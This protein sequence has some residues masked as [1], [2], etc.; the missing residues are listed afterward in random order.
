VTRAWVDDIDRDE[1]KRI[2]PILNR[3]LELD[4]SDVNGYLDDLNADA[5]IRE[6]VNRFMEVDGHSG[7]LPEP[8]VAR[9][10]ATPPRDDAVALP[11]R[12]GSYRVL[13]ELG[14]GGMGIV[15]LGYDEVFGRVVA[16]KTLPP[17]FAANASRVA[18]F[19]GEARI[20]AALCHP[21]IATI[22]GVERSRNGR[23]VLV[24]E[25]VE[26]QTLA[27]RVVAGDWSVPEVL[28]AARQ[29][30]G[31]LAAAHARGV[32]H[33]DLKPSNVMVTQRGLAKVLDFGI[34]G[35]VAE[36]PGTSPSALR[37]TAQ[38]ETRWRMG[39]LGYMSP[40]QL[41]GGQESIACDAFSFG[42]VLYECLTGSPA[43]L[44]VNRAAT[45]DA[46]LR[47]TV[48]HSKLPSDVPD[49]VCIMLRSLLAREPADRPSDL[50]EVADVLAEGL[51]TRGPRSLRKRTLDDRFPVPPGPLV[52]RD[53]DLETCRDAL[54]RSRLVTLTGAG[55]CGKTR[56]A[57]ELAGHLAA[58]E[59]EVVWF[60]DLSSVAEEAGF[61]AALATALN[62]PG[63]ESSGMADAVRRQ[64][65]DR[66]GLLILD[67]CE[68]QL[69]RSAAFCNAVLSA[70]PRLTILATSREWLGVPGELTL[71]ID[72]L[73]VPE[74][75]FQTRMESIA[76]NDS[77][78]LFM[79]HAAA[80]HPDFRL[81]ESNA[82]DIA[83]V[84]RTLDGIPL[85]LEL[86]AALLEQFEL[87]DIVAEL[88]SRLAVETSIAAH[89][90]RHSTLAAAIELSYLRLDAIERHAFESMSV[91]S[92]GFTLE[93][94]TA[95]CG[96]D[97]DHFGMLD[98]LMHLVDR[99]LL[100][101]ERMHRPDLRYRYLEPVRVFAE[102][103]L[104]A[105][106]DDAEPRRRHG[107]HFCATAETLEPSLSHGNQIDAL[108]RFEADHQNLLAALRAC[109]TVPGL[110][111]TQALRL[112]K[113]TWR[114]WY[115]RGQFALGRDAIKAALALP[116]AEDVP[117]LRAHVM[118]GA[119]VL[120]LYLR[121]DA[122]AL[123]W[124]REALALH[125]RGGDRFGEASTL[126][127]LGAASLQ[128]GRYER[129]RVFFE[130]AQRLFEA[131]DEPRWLALMLNNLGAVA[132][133][134]GDL[135]T[136]S[137]RF[138]QAI[139]LARTINNLDDLALMLVNSALAHVRLGWLPIA[140]E[141]IDEALAVVRVAGVKRVATAALEVAS[142]VLLAMGH[143][144]HAARLL[145]S[146]EQIR[147]EIGVPPDDDW[148]RAQQ[149]FLAHLALALEPGRY[150]DLMQQGR[151]IPWE[152]IVDHARKII[153]SRA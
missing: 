90:T 2:E 27:D 140:R 111:A 77:V 25:Y 26:G 150:R 31:A 97:A 145:G 24:L 68:H 75:A 43:V 64:L 15:Y 61:V 122:A 126:N 88:A 142:E 114:Y 123:R 96:D 45:M 9:P 87:H 80:A 41:L 130:G 1:W 152:E 136:A 21:N 138:E 104:Q 141:R 13:R 59:F 56:L 3:V 139:P 76:E 35:H 62:L 44:R 120:S 102:A 91:F 36:R 19:L 113:A 147:A 60:A 10:P 14:R 85:A 107:E 5:R 82:V 47:A 63:L 7:K 33:R 6:V 121:D 38:S 51:R 92:G 74:L 18:L 57:L 144:E 78:R 132:R 30:A 135:H 148:R 53:R 108:E 112:A 115:I 95:V 20:L 119:G 54:G 42:C 143:A 137:R 55:G 17:E 65:A 127:H 32:L 49:S 58:D 70:C 71:R 124:C 29:I 109:K 83:R 66:T 37:K 118:S 73:P 79:L 48:D 28:D 153:E 22:H 151:T 128:R 93:A 34:S 125:R 134:R 52:G 84:C 23:H 133:Q 100:R 101:V 110:G 50:L 46:T 116:G 86:A 106:G 8:F 11:E 4:A 67:N 69:A 40:E 72:P 99:S 129:A 117:R 16:L 39:T 12:L 89:P 94:A 105:S 131:L 81:D 98:R 146:A 149:P 103:R